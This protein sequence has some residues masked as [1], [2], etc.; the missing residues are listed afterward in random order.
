VRVKGAVQHE[1][2]EFDEL[3]WV[4]NR[5]EGESPAECGNGRTG[6]PFQPEPFD[7][8]LCSGT[9]ECPRPVLDR[10]PGVLV[11]APIRGEEPAVLRGCCVSGGHCGQR[12][13]QQPHAVAGVAVDIED[14]HQQRVLVPRLVRIFTSRFRGNVARNCVRGSRRS[15]SSAGQR[16]RCCGSSRAAATG[17]RRFLSWASAVGIVEGLADLPVPRGDSAKRNRR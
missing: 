1:R 5:P 6:S 16:G 14:V 9:F 11:I 3:A 4:A 13:L 8:Q 10:L 15:S 2:H 12:G 17:A 7:E